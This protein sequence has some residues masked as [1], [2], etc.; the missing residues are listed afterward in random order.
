MQ[1]SIQSLNGKVALITGSAQ[2]IGASFNHQLHAAGAS[3]IIHYRQ[4]S[5]EA[6]ALCDKLNSQRENSATLLQ[7]DLADKK[8][9]QQLITDSVQAFGRLDILVNN[10]SSFFPTPIGNA[11]DD[12]WNDLITS[13]LKAPF[14]LSQA[15]NNEL[16]KNRGVIVNMVDIHGQN[17]LA[18][19]P[20]YC[21]AKAGLIMLTRSLAKEMAPHVRVNGIAPGSILWPEGAAA[22]SDTKKTE[23][24]QQIALR[25]Q[26]DPEDLA[27]T[28]LYLVSDQSSYVT[29]QIIQ[30]DGGRSL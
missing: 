24:L 26:G 5:N 27:K 22:L 16:Q 6:R 14:F 29:G 19:H 21:A 1:T 15:A 17:P 9:Y 20:V 12:D 3:V 23:I 13:N 18:E 7:G 11:T 28:L 4:S 25:R 10:A 30:V 8:S 2:R